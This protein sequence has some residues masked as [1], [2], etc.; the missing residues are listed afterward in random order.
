MTPAIELRHEPIRVRDPKLYNT[1]T[2]THTH[3]RS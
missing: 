3:T 1:H 2:H